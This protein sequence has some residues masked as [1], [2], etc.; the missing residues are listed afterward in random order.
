[1]LTTTYAFLSLSTERKRLYD[2]L[3]EA[4]QLFHI[5]SLNNQPLDAVTLESVV[6]EFAKL[7][8]SCLRRKVVMYVMPAVQKATK[9]ASQLLAE[10][11]SSHALGRQI[12][13]SIREWGRLALMQKP[14]DTDELRLSIDRYC[15]NLLE[16]LVKEEKELLPLAQRV[17]SSEE[18]FA[19]GAKFLSIDTD[20]MA[21]G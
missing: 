16:R 14:M 8:E 19:M 7:D 12:L 10:L 11:E 18:W 6:G 9:E 20:H 1:M 3:G 2:L 4:R 21:R 5:H 13:D 15:K 17:I